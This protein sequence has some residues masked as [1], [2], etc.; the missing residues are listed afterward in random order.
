[1][2]QERDIARTIRDELLQF[3]RRQGVSLNL[4]V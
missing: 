3:A 4:G 1:V 2:V